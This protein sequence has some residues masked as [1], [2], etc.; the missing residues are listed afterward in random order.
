M[1]TVVYCYN[2]GNTDFQNYIDYPFEQIQTYEID[3]ALSDRERQFLF[4]DTETTGLPRLRDASYKDTSNWPRLVQIAWILSD[5]N[6]NIISKKS[7][8]IKPTF[9]I[10]QSASLIHKITTQKALEEGEP[11]EYVLQ[12]LQND[13]NRCTDIVAHNLQYDLNVIACEFYRKSLNSA[14]FDKQ[15]ICTMEETTNYC[16]IDGKYGYRWPKLSELHRKLFECNFEEAH[17]ASVDIDVTFKC[18]KELVAKRI[19][20][21]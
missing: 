20:N 19:I 11:I 21:I 18:F 12:L 10:P 16:A 9:T 17:N 14:L 15:Q 7:F 2:V 8:I 4:V 3:L 1:K 13:I 5:D 6:L